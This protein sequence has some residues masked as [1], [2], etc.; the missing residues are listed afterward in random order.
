MD[1]PGKRAYIFGKTNQSIVPFLND[2]R[3]MDQKS[4]N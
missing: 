3:R 2:S 1:A 4:G